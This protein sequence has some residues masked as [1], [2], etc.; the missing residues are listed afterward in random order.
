[1]SKQQQKQPPRKVIA[2]GDPLLILLSATRPEQAGQVNHSLALLHARTQDAVR[3]GLI[4]KL[5]VDVPTHNM[6]A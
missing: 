3:L 2:E 4:A 5:G 1:M 6:R